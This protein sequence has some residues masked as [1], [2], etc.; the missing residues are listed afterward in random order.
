MEKSPAYV[1]PAI[2]SRFSDWLRVLRT[3]T[4][5]MIAPRYWP[6][7]LVVGLITLLSS[8]FQWYERLRLRDKLRK[9]VLHPSPVF[10]IGHWRSG[11]TFLHNLL[12]QDK[13][14]GY[15]STLQSV[16]PHS[17]LT[18]H[19]FPHLTRLSMPDTRPMDDMRLFLESPQEEEMAL[20]NYGPY[21]FY[22]AWHFPSRMRAIF[23]RVV[24]LEGISPEERRRWLDVYRELLTKTTLRAG[25][26]RLLLKSPANTARLRLLLELF[27]DARFIFLHRDPLE[28][29]ASTLKLYRNVLPYF[30]LERY[31]WAQVRRD[32]LWVYRELLTDYLTDRAL[33][34]DGH[35]VELAYADLTADPMAQL[36][37]LY[38]E[39]DLGDFTIAAPRFA[40]YLDLHRVKN[41]PRKEYALPPE[42][43]EE[44]EKEWGFAFE[45]WGTK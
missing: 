24:R 34:P 15:V 44:V 26:R 12:S 11:T 20:V 18:N 42:E 40:A 7:L 16:F 4:P 31:D 32:I 8:P 36:E 29:Y 43:M 6:R 3:M 19:L 5:G 39:L 37:R 25:G 41:Y 1:T 10:I 28:V 30:Q 22:H 35:L 27:P 45:V 38:E 14:F 17:F 13:Q 2:G 9:T 23:R 33:V 21:S